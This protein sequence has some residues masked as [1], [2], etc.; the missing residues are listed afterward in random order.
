MTPHETPIRAQ[1]PQ[2]IVEHVKFST[3][4]G[5]S[6]DP[7]DGDRGGHQAHPRRRS[8]RARWQASGRGNPWTSPRWA[9]KRSSTSQ[10]ERAAESSEL[11]VLGV[12]ARSVLGDEVTLHTFLRQI[13]LP[14]LVPLV[15]LV[16]GGPQLHDPP[17]HSH[18]VAKNVQLR[19]SGMHVRCATGARLRIRRV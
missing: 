6:V 1:E 12:R 2:A 4:A 9:I 16:N 10:V 5:M 3:A 13:E 15:P 14:C 18:R 19:H 8:R 11:L 7:N 17:P